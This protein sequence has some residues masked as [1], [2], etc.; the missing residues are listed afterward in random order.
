MELFYRGNHEEPII[1]GTNNGVCKIQY[2]EDNPLFV[3]LKS[4]SGNSQFRIDNKLNVH[5]GSNHGYTAFILKYNFAQHLNF[6]KG[7]T[8]YSIPPYG[9]N[10]WDVIAGD[11]NLANDVSEL[12]KEYGLYLIL[13]RVSRS[14]KIKKLS[15]RDNLILP[16]NSI[17][18]SLQRFV[19]LK[20]M[21]ASNKNAVLLFEE[22]QGS[23][24]SL[25]IMREIIRSAENQFFIVTHNTAFLNELIEKAG[26]EGAVFVV[27]CPD[28]Q[29]S[30]RKLSQNEL[31]DVSR[32][33]VD[34]ITN[35]E[36][37]I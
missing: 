20:T 13:D 19:F 21:I 3:K 23:S 2:E 25:D 16:Y 4:S 27:S 6:M 34:L 29:T 8:N 7:E 36:S 5:S 18:T 14:L 35:V 26:E 11:E 28:N 10:L 9:Y 33:G 32:D 30:I 22:P 24:Y 37:Y 12:F 17:A 15:G 1:I 31:A